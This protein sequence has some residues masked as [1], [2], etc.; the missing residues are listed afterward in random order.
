M[1]RVAVWNYHFNQGETIEDGTLVSLIVECDVIEHNAF[2]VVEA[3]MNFPVLPLNDTSIDLEAHTFW[4]SNIDW[5]DI[6]PIA[7]FRLHS[8][9]VVVVWLGF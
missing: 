7:S 6:L 8:C 9:D 1:L 4:L 5:L 3:N 2:L